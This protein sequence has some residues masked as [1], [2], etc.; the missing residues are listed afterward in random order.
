MRTLL[1]IFSM[2]ILTNIHSQ[3]LGEK[4]IG[5]WEVKQIDNKI[6]TAGVITYFEFTKNNEIFS[7]SV[8]GESHGVI[9]KEKLLG[10]FTIEKDKAVY[11]TEESSFEITIKEDHQLVVK[12]LKTKN[13]ETYLYRTSYLFRKD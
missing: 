3:N 4:L 13:N 12:E 7:K 2:L 8:N 1:F 5:K 9:P 6:F 11:E 10:K